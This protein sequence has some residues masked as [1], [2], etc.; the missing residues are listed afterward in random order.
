MEI[1]LDDRH[2]LMSD[3]YCYWIETEVIP[4]EGKKKPY[5][6]RISGY[7][8]TFEQV[9]ESYI[10]SKIKSSEVMKLNKLSN[11]I[12]ALKEEVRGWHETYS[13]EFKG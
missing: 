6:K 7:T 4:E 9:V 3:K 8:P 1:K 5:R 13:R 10:N 12:K 11:E 2:F